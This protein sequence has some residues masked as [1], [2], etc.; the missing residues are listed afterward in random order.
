MT[1]DLYICGYTKLLNS[2]VVFCEI[3]YR[4]ILKKHEIYCIGS[5][6]YFLSIFFL[7]HFE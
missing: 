4:K 7:E 5:E 2:F 3:I 1:I 6:Y